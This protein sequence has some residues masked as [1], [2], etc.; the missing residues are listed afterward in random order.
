MAD[1][2]LIEQEMFQLDLVPGYA[3]VI[4]VVFIYSALSKQPDLGGVY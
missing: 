3:Q 2:T 1:A 4:F